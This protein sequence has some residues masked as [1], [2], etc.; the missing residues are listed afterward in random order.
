MA[1]RVRRAQAGKASGPRASR[2]CR[3]ASV[4]VQSIDP[5]CIHG[6]GCNRAAVCLPV[7]RINQGAVGRSPFA[8]PTG[9]DSRGDVV[10]FLQKTP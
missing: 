8:I 7:N 9:P 4:D 2:L 6:A 10:H 1:R 5:I 3:Q